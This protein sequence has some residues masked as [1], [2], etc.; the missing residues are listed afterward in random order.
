MEMR[1]FEYL[2]RLIDNEE[3][4]VVAVVSRIVAAENAAKRGRTGEVRRLITTALEA[5]Q[6]R[7]IGAPQAFLIASVIASGA[8]LGV[9]ME[10][11]P[12]LDG[13]RRLAQRLPSKERALALRQIVATLA[14]L[15]RLA[16]ARMMLADIDDDKER[17]RASEILGKAAAHAGRVPDLR[18]LLASQDD[19]GLARY[20]LVT[21]IA[22]G[23]AAGQQ[24]AI[25]PQLDSLLSVSERVV[26]RITAA[27]VWRESSAVADPDELLNEALR[28]T[29]VAPPDDQQELLGE[30]AAELL[31]TVGTTTRS[32]W[33]G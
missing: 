10:T 14:Q 32:Q 33:H 19:D 1:D 25:L 12:L 21:G 3:M 2:Q 13:A 9:P 18:Y 4:A 8:S 31:K 24:T 28:I 27:R 17:A 26:V 22:E 7:A 29:S 23:L 20:S 15:D 16:D 30:L 5:S 11:K 6:R